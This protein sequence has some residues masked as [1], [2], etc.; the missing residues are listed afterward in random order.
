VVGHYACPRCFGELPQETDQ[1]GGFFCAACEVAYPVLGG[2]ACLVPDP[3]LFRRVWKG[4]LDDTMSLSEGRLA[5]LRDEASAPGLLARTRE[6]I[7]RVRQALELD[8]NAIAELFHA[9]VPAADDGVPALFPSADARSEDP[10]L[11]RYSEHL[12]RDWVWGE[13]DCE[14]ALSFVRRLL[15]G[16]LGRVAVYGVGSGRLA[17][18]IHRALGP[19]WTLGLDVNPLPLIVGARL[20]AGSEVLL[21]EFPLAPL[22]DE[23][24]AVRQR[25]RSPVALPSG[26][27]LAFADALNPPLAPGSLDTV[28]TP[29]FVDAVGADLRV[30]ARAVNRVLKPGGR[31]L[32]FGPLRFT[33]PP[34]AQYLEGEVHELV[35]SSSFTLAQKLAEDLP[36]FRSPF[37]GTARIDRVF[38]FAAEKTAEA[39][40]SEPAHLFAPWLSDTSL[41]IPAGKGLAVLRKKSVLT[42]G[43][44]SM[45]DGRR[46]IRD[47]ARELGAQWG[48]PPSIVEEQLAPFLASLPLD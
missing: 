42:I 46:S 4:R 40:A 1:G 47:L 44:V 9:F 34:A 14:R 27:E 18:D 30:I 38:A 21:H 17:L 2:V 13:E 20:L 12:F 41:P 26:L 33:G 24:V 28:V 31:W 3:T 19:E 16:S 48:V 8:R 43:I 10:P 29:W 35:E 37:S 11:L 6:R 7:E 36:Y 32:N 23:V 39:S 15:P 22:S 45:I 25:L 5:R